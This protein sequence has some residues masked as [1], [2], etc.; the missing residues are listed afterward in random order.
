MSPAKLFRSGRRLE[1]PDTVMKQQLLWMLLLRVILYTLLLGISFFLQDDR[2]EVITIPPN[3]LVLFILGVYVVTIG[4]ALVLIRTT[5]ELRRFGFIQAIID[6]LF[7]ALLVYLS[8]GSQSIFTSIF[9]FPIISAG[10]L[11]PIKG[12][13]IA[14]AASTLLYGGVLGLEYLQIIP[15]YLSSYDRYGAKS[16]QA[17]INL[18]AVKGLTFFLAAVISALFGARLKTTADALTSTRLDYD[19]L[20]LLY[21]EIFDNI[22]TG[23]ITLNGAGIVSSANNATLSI[24]GMKLNELMGHMFTEVL[25]EIRLG[26]S[27]PRKACDYERGGKKIRIGYA[28]TTLTRPVRDPEAKSESNQDEEIT[29]ITLKDISEIERLEAQMRQAEKLAAIGMMSAGIAHDFRNPLTAISG[30]AQLMAQEFSRVETSNPYNYELTKIILRESDRLI[31]TIADFLKFARPDTIDRE[32]FQLKPCVEEILQV[33]K[34]DPKW[35][36]TAKIRV[37]MDDRFRIWA[38]EKQMFTVINHLIQNGLAFCKEGEEYLHIHAENKPHLNAQE[39]SC[40]MVSDNGPGVDPDHRSQI[41][42]PFFTSRTDGTG[43]GLA[44][45][46]Q[47]VEAH[48]GFIEVGQADPTGA[49]FTICL[50]VEPPT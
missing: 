45:V 20:S 27:S 1:S 14:A 17:S 19:R 38:D 2:F 43:L 10:L 18:F 9:F 21:K 42:E 39:M 13:L 40:I 4:S 8:G 36:E 23:I 49:A 5:R 31:K 32:W 29:I 7:A 24:T 3:L 33:C 11:I 48:N 47:T 12:G 26:N 6:T 37:D 22:T 15:D 35:P 50:P 46:K 41:F 28:H 34:A 16:I 44:I 25:P 30:S